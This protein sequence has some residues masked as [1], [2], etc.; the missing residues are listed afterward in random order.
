MEVKKK[1]R[2]FQKILESERALKRGESRI[3][4]RDK[5][6]NLTQRNQLNKS[7]S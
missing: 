6:G 1:I 2:K 4:G 3:A 5:T 7:P